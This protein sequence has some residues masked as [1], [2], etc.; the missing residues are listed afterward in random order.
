MTCKC[1]VIEKENN[2]WIIALSECIDGYQLFGP[3]ESKY[4]V[5]AYIK[6][7]LESNITT[8]EFYDFEHPDVKILINKMKG[9]PFKNKY[10][11]F[12]DYKILAWRCSGFRSRR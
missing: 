12:E 9:A 1:Q 6:Q 10:W 11:D 2:C 4:E 5:E 8:T 7:Y 3:F